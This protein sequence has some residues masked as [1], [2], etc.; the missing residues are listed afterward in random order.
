METKPSGIIGIDSDI[1]G[2]PLVI[3]SALVKYVRK[4]GN[5]MMQCLGY[6]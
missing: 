6:S 5:T 2:Q 4:N 3:H 1:T